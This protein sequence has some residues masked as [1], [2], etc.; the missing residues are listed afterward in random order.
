MKLSKSPIFTS[1]YHVNLPVLKGSY[2]WKCY[3]VLKFQQDEGPRKGFL[4]PL[5]KGSLTAL[6]RTTD[7]AMRPPPTLSQ[8][9]P[10]LLQRF[11]RFIVCWHCLTS[12]TGHG[13]AGP[14]HPGAQPQWQHGR[15]YRVYQYFGVFLS[16][17]VADIEISIPVWSSP[18]FGPIN[19]NDNTVELIM[20]F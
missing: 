3:R 6:I 19:L 15:L 16:I 10:E 12:K 4:R 13:P 11:R 1:T 7:T 20:E 5:H 9:F 18:L 2:L 8:S 17:L 14:S